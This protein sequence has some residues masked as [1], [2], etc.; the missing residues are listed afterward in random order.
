MFTAAAGE[1]VNQM[2]TMREGIGATLDEQVVQASLSSLRTAYAPLW[3]GAPRWILPLFACSL[4]ARTH[5]RT[6]AHT[7]STAF[8]RPI[9]DKPM[10]VRTV[11]RLALAAE[12]ALVVSQRWAMFVLQLVAGW[13]P[14]AGVFYWRRPTL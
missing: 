12:R 7:H 2:K 14:S 8:A 4:H 3:D 13:L 10:C 9:I 1:I 5:A 11:H 6:Y